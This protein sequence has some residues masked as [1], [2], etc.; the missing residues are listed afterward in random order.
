MPLAS[1]RACVAGTLLLGLGT[2]L[3]STADEAQWI[4]SP[5]HTKR[6]VPQVACYFR[7]VFDAQTPVRVQATIGADDEYELYVNGRKVGSGG[8]TREL[9]E[10]NIT[11]Y[12]DR[13]RNVIAVKVVNQTGPTA[14][15][16]ARVSLREK[17]GGWVTYSTDKTWRTSLRD[18]ESWN[19]ALFNDR[20][21]ETA[22]SFGMLGET[23]PWDR[24][25]DA[26]SDDVAS[27]D[28]ASDDA[29][30]DDVASGA[31]HQGGGF[32][33][34]R[35]FEVQRVLDGE[36]TGSLIA[37]AFNEF[38][39]IVAS[40]EN[41]P[42]LLVVDTDRNGIVDEARVYC[43]LVT[44]VQG[45]LPLNGNVYVT[46][47]GPEGNGLYCLSDEDR[48]GSLE[49]ARL[50]FRFR[51][52]VGEHAAHGLTLGPDG[53]IYIVMGNRSSPEIPYDPGSPH[54]GYYEGDLVGPRYEDPGG[55]AVGVK[56]P[57]GVIIRI[58]PLGETVHLVSGGL[59][60]ADD[61]AFNAEGEL[62][63]HDGE[64]ESDLG[65]TWYRPT[66]VCHVTSG[67]E[68]GW[69]SG[70][71]KW[72]DYYLDSL[73]AIAD[74]GRGSPTGAVFYNHHMFPEQYRDSLFLADW[75]AGRILVARLRRQAPVSRPT[76]KYSSKVS[77]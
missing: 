16:V 65:T 41:G 68:F 48:D 29:A 69:R 43:E 14:A 30:S 33:I 31:V 7:K 4:W 51:G 54:R 21:W 11:R 60:N 19:T 5:R 62:F 44:N 28:A 20:T 15:L 73:P 59:C 6:E 66:R 64:M 47:Q 26:A 13:G 67:S 38:G 74:T 8:A 52:E 71:A 45:I 35:E 37:M 17:E 36:T 34:A 25:D 42:L 70:W 57:G 1:M 24:P 53:W 3:V 2:T 39:H 46:G 50:L 63:V 27:D 72:P 22:Q 18:P 76:R 55:H 61:L 58:D 10:Y 75:S 49:S 32:R 12:V 9:D 77:R 23:T 56:A 40:R